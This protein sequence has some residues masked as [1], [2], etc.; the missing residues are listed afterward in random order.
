MYVGRVAVEKNI[1]AFL[2]LD[3]GGTK[4][5]VGDGPQRASLQQ[6]FP[7]VVFTGAKSG[8]ELAA[9]FRSADAFVFASRTDTFGLVM[10]E[11]MACGT[12]VAA[13]PVPGPLDVVV[14]GVSGILDD[15]LRAG[16]LAALGLDRAKVRRSALAYSWAGATAQFLGN[17]HPRRSEPRAA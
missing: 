2:A 9:H 14:P 4:V 6:R 3:V 11:A 8:E 5:V 15:D 13:Y 16:A 1:A 12:P 17:L 10:L 7:G